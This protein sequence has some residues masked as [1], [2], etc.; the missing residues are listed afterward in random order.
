MKFKMVVA[1]FDWTLGCAPGVIEQSTI[2]AIRRY[3]EKGGIFTVCTGRLYSSISQILRK[4][5]LHGKV[6][7]CQGAIIADIDTGERLYTDGIDSALAAKAVRKLREDGHTVFLDYDDRLCFSERTPYTDAYERLTGLQGC[8]KEDIAGFIE[9]GH[10]VVQ[11]IMVMCETERIADI[12]K[13]YNDYFGGKLLVNSGS[14]NLVEIVNPACSK[15][16][17]TL[18]LAQ[19]YGVRPEEVLAVGDSTNDLSLTEKGFYS[20]AVGDGSEAL[21]AAA[22]EITV[23]FAEKPVET[24][25]KKY[26][27]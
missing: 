21:K 11:K 3:E 23:P 13:T 19:K 18:F 26:C 2:E 25:L 9:K 6:I 14:K 5:G 27:L 20:V 12:L 1:D 17:S 24:L 8:V 15:G 16:V 7:A 4:Y 10:V 22:N